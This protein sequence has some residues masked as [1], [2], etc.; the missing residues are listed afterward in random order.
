MSQERTYIMVKPDGVQR[1]LVGEIVKRFEQ[2]GF[3]L[4]GLKMVK[5]TSAHLEEHYKDLKGKGFFNGLIKY[6]SSGPVVAMVWGGKSVVKTG[7]MMLGATNPLDSTPGTIRGDFCI[8]VGRNVCHGSDSVE[9][10]ER[11][12]ALW[13][14][15]G[16]NSYDRSIHSQIYE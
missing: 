2:R 10:A 4:L 11:E 7:R 14:P 1:G 5:P 15:E 8:D 3:Q 13:F 16:V 6:M 9:S 12:I